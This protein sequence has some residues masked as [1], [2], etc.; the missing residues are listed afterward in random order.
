[1]FND[2]NIGPITIHMYGLMIAIGFMSA[3]FLCLKRGKKKDLDED[4]IYGILYCALLGALV[5][6]RLLF[7]IVEFPNILENPSILWNFREGYVVYGGIIGG[8]FFAYIYIAKIKKADFLEYLDLT[9]PSVAFAQGFGRLG[10]FFAGCCY[11]AETDSWFH[12]VFHN[13]A[14][15]PNNV[16][17]IPTQLIS[18]AGDFIIALLL[19]WYERKNPMKGRVTA[20]YFLL[21]GL[22]RFIIEF[23]RNDYRGNIGFLSTSQL[24]SIGIVVIGIIVYFVVPSQHRKHLQK[25]S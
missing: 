7:Y 10:C 17:L 19:L 24:I 18:S 4:I 8:I 22:G 5:G 15:A 14:Y 3:L 12:I 2:L 20:G 23:F 16:P 1:M 21:Y 11:G 13:S 9:M 25:E 6:C